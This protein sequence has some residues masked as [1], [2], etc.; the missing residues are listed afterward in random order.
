M[1]RPNLASRNH[2]MRAS[3]D[4]GAAAGEACAGATGAQRQATTTRAMIFT[5]KNRANL[6]FMTNSS[7]SPLFPH[8]AWPIS[9]G[10]QPQG[11]LG[12][13]A[14]IFLVDQEPLHGTSVTTRILE[15]D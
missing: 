11:C 12:E 9:I 8:I 15:A 10:G 3:W 14:A 7:V 2:F 6:R 1:N 4:A 13:I 5:D